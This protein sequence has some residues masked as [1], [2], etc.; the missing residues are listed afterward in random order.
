MS[1]GEKIVKILAVFHSHGHMV[2]CHAEHD[3]LM[4]CEDDE[5]ISYK[6]EL[7]DAGAFFSS[8]YSLWAVWC[9]A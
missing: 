4:F 3:I 7:E 5:D 1:N 8:E 9:S 2:A 6:D